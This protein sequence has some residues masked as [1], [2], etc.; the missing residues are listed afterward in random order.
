MCTKKNIR[1]IKRTLTMSIRLVRS[2]LFF[3]Y[4]HILITGPFEIFHFTPSRLSPF[5]LFV[6]LVSRLR[7]SHIM[8]IFVEFTKLIQ[9]KGSMTGVFECN[10]PLKDRNGRAYEADIRRISVTFVRKFLYLSNRL[11]TVFISRI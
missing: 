8:N 5:L 10:V 9:R 4:N 7:G 2:P 3:T 11:I 6:H 1:G